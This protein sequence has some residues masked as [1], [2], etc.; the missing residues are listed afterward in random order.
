VSLWWSESTGPLLTRAVFDVQ[1][2]ETGYE[3]DGRLSVDV[4]PEV[5]GA[6]S[7]LVTDLVGSSPP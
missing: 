3:G 1:R 6:W 7:A 2:A 5:V 4:A